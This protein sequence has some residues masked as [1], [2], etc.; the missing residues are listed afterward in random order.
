MVEIFGQVKEYR[1]LQ[2]LEFT[3]D[4]KKMTVIVQDLESGFVFLFTKGA[5][6]AIFDRLSNTIE[7]P[8]LD[9]TKEDLIKFSTKGFRTLCFA[10]RVL[11]EEK[12]YNWQERYEN[13]KLEM[14]KLGMKKLKS[15]ITQENISEKLQNEIE[16]DLFLIGATALE[17]KL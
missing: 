11:D 8:F 3:S 13:S 12:F 10:M 14:I 4:R 7:Q 2:K 1:L 5:D 17:D 15:E 16:D 6:L 9:A